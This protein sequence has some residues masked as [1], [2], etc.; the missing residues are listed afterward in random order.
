MPQLWLR[1]IWII[2]IYYGQKTGSGNF[3][4]GMFC[5]VLTFS[6]DE[7]LSAEDH[8][9]I[10]TIHHHGIKEWRNVNAGS[11]EVFF[12]Q[13]WAKGMAAMA[14]ITDRFN[15]SEGWNLSQHPIHWSMWIQTSVL[16]LWVSISLV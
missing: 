15:Q 5:K 14:Q 7:F 8:G 10:I 12:H 13:T 16:I 1:K 6:C 4:N 2:I 9:E 11:E 3:W